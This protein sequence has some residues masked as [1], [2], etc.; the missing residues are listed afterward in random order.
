[1][2]IRLGDFVGVRQEVLDETAHDLLGTSALRLHLRPQ[3]HALEHERPQVVHH[4]EHVVRH[5]QLAPPQRLVDDGIDHGLDPLPSGLAEG[6][7]GLVREVAPVEHAGPKGVLGVVRQVGDAVGEPDHGTLRRAGALFHLP[8]VG[9]DPVDDLVCQVERLQHLE[10]AHALIRVA[11]LPVDELAQRV[12]PRVAEWRVTHVVTQTDGLG[13]RLVE[14]QRTGDGPSD[15]SDL[16]GVRQPSD[17][18]VSLG[19]HEHLCLVFQPPERLR[20]EDAVAVPFECSAVGV[21]CFWHATPSGVAAQRRPG[22]EERHLLP[23]PI[24]A[25]APAKG[26]VGRHTT[27]S[28]SRELR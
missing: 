7:D 17:E 1:M 5:R 18:V 9:L 11:P 26:G 3:I 15:L 23:L 19:V 21:W 27:R 22:C 16:E 24:L 2:A 20:V 28:R 10:D 12:L 13:E 25:C 14:R 4:P 6:G 8:R